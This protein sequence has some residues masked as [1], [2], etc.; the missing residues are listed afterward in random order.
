[1]ASVESNR[2][3]RPPAPRNI[4]L[5][6]RCGVKTPAVRE[7]DTKDRS[8]GVDLDTFNRTRSLDGQDQIAGL[9]GVCPTPPVW[10]G[11][12]CGP[13]DARVGRL[14]HADLRRRVGG[15]RVDPVDED[16]S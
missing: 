11:H 3:E 14:D 4:E 5:G 7:L 6:A 16:H 10:C 15:A 2:Y 12:H 13:R 1:M 8:R 9:N